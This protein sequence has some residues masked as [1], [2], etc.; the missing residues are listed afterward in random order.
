[1]A[2]HQHDEKMLADSAFES[3][4]HAH[5]VVGNR[6]RMLDPRRTPVRVLE[7]RAAIGAFVIR[8]EAFEDEGAEWEIPFEE[9][10]RFQFATGSAT[11]SA[12]TCAEIR[13]AIA[14]FDQPLRIEIDRE[15]RATTLALLE[16]RTLEAGRWLDR[17]SRF[18]ES[19]HELPDPD[20]READPLLFADLEAYFEQRGLVDL[21]TAFARQFVSNPQAGELVKGHR[22]VIAELG[23]V[24]FEGRA[25]RSPDLFAGAWSGERR[26]DHIIS[27]LAFVRSLYRRL[28][29][30]RVVLYRGLSCPGPL[31]PPR[32]RTFVSAT[33]SHE[34]ARSLYDAGRETWTRVI[35]RQAVPVERI[36]MT[37]HE[38]A[39]MNAQYREAEAVLLF[40]E[41]NLAF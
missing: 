37:Y 3:G 14:L 22:M 9:I 15:C 16:E 18:L 20:T 7:L 41:E 27:R 1:M 36:F 19:D 38:T 6:G 5:L 23:L 4:T 26:A 8:I 28:G 2:I 32:N 31:P 21:E 39:A 40:D 34:V 25:Q 17:H 24:E 12:E 35:Y 29:R 13:A 30:D 10:G 33:F 11:A